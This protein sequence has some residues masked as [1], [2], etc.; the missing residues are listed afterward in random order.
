MGASEG[1]LK[2]QFLYAIMANKE[3]RV[4]DFLGVSASSVRIRIEIPRLREHLASEW[5]DQPDVPCWL[6]WPC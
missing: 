1:K 2:E 4:N 6:P 5:H 3:G